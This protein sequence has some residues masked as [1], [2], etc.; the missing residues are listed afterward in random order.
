VN[1]FSNIDPMSII[2]NL[3]KPSD[4]KHFHHNVPYRLFD[5]KEKLFYNET[6]SSLNK[7]IGCYV[8]SLISSN[9]NSSSSIGFGFKFEPLVGSNLTMLNNINDLICNKLPIGTNYSYQFSLVADRKL[10]HML[11]NNRVIHSTRK[12]MYQ[13]LADIQFK[14]NLKAIYDGFPNGY[15]DNARFD[16]KNY[17]IWFFVHGKETNKEKMKELKKEINVALDMYQI[18]TIEITA[19]DLIEYTTDILSRDIHAPFNKKVSY[20]SCQTLDKQIFNRA[21]LMIDKIEPEYIDVKFSDHPNENKLNRIVCMTVSELPSEFFAGNL[22]SCLSSEQSLGLSIGCPFLWT[23]GFMGEN[24]GKSR[25]Q[26]S[27]KIKSLDKLK[28]A[29]LE[30]WFPNLNEEINDY[31]DIEKGLDANKYIIANFSMDIL[32]F[33]D[34]RNWKKE[35]EA[36]FNLFRQQGIK[37]SSCKYL[38][39]QILQSVMPFYFDNMISDRKKTGTTHRV[40]SNNIANLVPI[41][42][43]YKGAFDNEKNSNYYEYQYGLLTP[44]NHNQI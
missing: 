42:A 28:K 18:K 37:L 29:G 12:G 22:P 6:S 27:K 43:D 40:K 19:Q 36:T 32:L 25:T 39:G 21:N 34:K 10:Y 31:I 1:F 20:N 24:R 35:R 38:Q 5:P 16:L 3:A 26:A 41:V 15:G 30:R 33:T 14:Y 4:V 44:T 23:L 2:K 13:S 17:M 7:K 11:N 9:T 8:K